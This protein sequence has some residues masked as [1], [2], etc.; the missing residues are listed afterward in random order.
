[1]RYAE[2]DAAASALDSALAA[3]FAQ[4][5]SFWTWAGNIIAR[6][7]SEFGT[8]LLSYQDQVE[9]WKVRASFAATPDEA[10]RLIASAETIL[11][12]IRAAQGYESK[13]TLRR[14]VLETISDD[15]NVE[16]LGGALATVP[17]QVAEK[18]VAPLVPDDWEY[19]VAAIAA[20][21]FVALCIFI[22]LRK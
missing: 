17:K 21:V 8:L 22:Y 16:T 18:I 3:A 19:W 14:A 10:N 9:R 12:G 20:L 1:M 11:N 4:S 7:D 6:T 2:L 13:V 15:P 5:D